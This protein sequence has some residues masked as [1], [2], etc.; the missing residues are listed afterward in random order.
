MDIDT[1]IITYNTA[2]T[3]AAS[4]VLGKECRWKKPLTTKDVI[5]ICDERKRGDTKHKEQKPTGKLT[6]RFRRQCR[7][8]KRTAKVFSVRRLKLA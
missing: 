2:L 1:M 8:Q 6:R 7:K 5:D 4:E 3:D